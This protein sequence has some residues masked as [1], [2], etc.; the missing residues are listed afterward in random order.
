MRRAA[1]LLFGVVMGAVLSAALL[2]A[3]P[4]VASAVPGASA[5]GNGSMIDYVIARGLSQRGVP[6]SYGGGGV[7]GPTRGV[8]RYATV[9]G[10]DASGLT[11]YAFAG[12]GIK[13]PRSSTTQY[14]VGRKIPPAQA[15]RGDLIFY[16]PQGS[17]SV[18]LYLGNQQML[19]VSD[20]V[21]VA[22]VRSAEM[23]PYLVRILDS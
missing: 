8:G 11:Q 1:A 23:T 9:V 16:G 2:V 17:Q 15:K 3:T 20:T 12:A 13:L 22:A 6:F 7:S 5:Q 4:G 14:Q 19:E 21:N 18:A 10:F